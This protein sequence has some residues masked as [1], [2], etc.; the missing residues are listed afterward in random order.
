VFLLVPDQLVLLTVRHPALIARVRLIG[1]VYVLVRGQVT[2]LRELPAADVAR[3][4]RVAGVNAADVRAQVSYL[5]EGPVTHNARVR[6]FACVHS[7]VVHQVANV[8]EP[9]AAQL[10]LALVRRQV[11]S[12]EPLGWEHARA[13]VALEVPGA[14]QAHLLDH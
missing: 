2:H 10:A 5:C 9:F 3:V 1:V 7:H 13:L 8:S 6:L 14:L 12:Q 4:R 11:L